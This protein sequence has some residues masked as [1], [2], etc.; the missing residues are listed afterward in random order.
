MEKYILT[1]DREQAKVVSRACDLLSRLHVG[2]IEE[3]RWEFIRIA[4]N[5]G[6]GSKFVV[7]NLTDVD[8]LLRDLKN[9]VCRFGEQAV[10]DVPVADNAYNVHQ[11]LR[12]A[13]AHHDCPNGGDTVDFHKSIPLGKAEI[14]ICEIKN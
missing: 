1:L 8:I 14:P 4:Q 3:L 10:G 5:A 13:M 9:L 11:A 7:N 6:Y 12:Y 2:Q